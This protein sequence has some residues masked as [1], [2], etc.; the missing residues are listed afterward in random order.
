MKLVADQAM[1]YAKMG[2]GVIPVW[3][4][5]D[6]WEDKRARVPWGDYQLSRPSLQTVQKWGEEGLFTGVA[7]LCGEV[8]GGLLCVDFDDYHMAEQFEASLTHL[9]KTRRHSS[10]R[11]VHYFYKVGRG[12]NLRSMSVRGIGDILWHGK[13]VVMPPT[14]GYTVLSDCEPMAL[15]QQEVDMIISFFERVANRDAQPVTATGDVMM[16]MNALRTYYRNQVRTMGRNNALFATARLARDHGYSSYELTTGGL[17]DEFVMTNA[18]NEEP[19]A[20]LREGKRTIDSAFSRAGRKRDHDS[21]IVRG[22]LSDDARERLCVAKLD[23]VARVFDALVSVGIRP[24]QKFTRKDA[25]A[26]L[27]GVVGKHSILNALEA[28]WGNRVIFRKAHYARFYFESTL[29]DFFHPLNALFREQLTAKQRVLKGGKGGNFYNNPKPEHV[30]VMPSADDLQRM[31]GAVYMVSTRVSSDDLSSI[32]AYRAKLERGFIDRRPNQYSRRWLGNRLGVVGRTTYNY[33]K[34]NG[35]YAETMYETLHTITWFNV[36]GL[37]KFEHDAQVFI[38]AGGRNYPAKLGVALRLLGQRKQP[39]LKRQVTNRYSTSDTITKTTQKPLAFSADFEQIKTLQKAKIDTGTIFVPGKET[40]FTGYWDKLQKPKA[41]VPA[42]VQA[43]TLTDDLSSR[44]FMS[45][46]LAYFDGVIAD[47]VEA[48]QLP[49]RDKRPD[50]GLL[51]AQ[52]KE[53]V[54]MVSDHSLS[55]ES[56]RK[57]IAV[58]GYPKVKKAVRLVTIEATVKQIRNMA[59]KV[60]STLNMLK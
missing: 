41:P 16:T 15:L 20:R 47:M 27:S 35:V 60:V 17:L 5:V 7:V 12:V 40:D 53:I 22:M 34:I 23:H 38:S 42:T 36:E 25:I 1:Q 19:R 54:G 43:P 13:Y 44:D 30:Y 6:G 26:K 32:K 33:H 10:R 52:A 24:K 18:R 29:S 56:A 37:F 31:T 11:G 39:V 55:V 4:G 21:M 49:R 8:S 58:H 9:C 2:Y 51:K 28:V 59:G 46:W 3:M 45:G 14:I 48:G 57:L 50:N